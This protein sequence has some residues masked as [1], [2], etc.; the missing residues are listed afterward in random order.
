MN[1][2]LRE[3]KV[4]DDVV[5]YKTNQYSIT[6]RD[7]YLAEFELFKKNDT[8]L[9]NF[10]DEIWICSSGIKR[11]EVNFRYDQI[12]YF[13]H[14]GQK[15]NISSRDMDAMLRC[16]VIYICGGYIFHT[17]ATK[18]TEVKKFITHY[19]D[20]G[21]R[22]TASGKLAILEFLGFI[23][24]PSHEIDRVDRTLIGVQ[25]KPAGQRELSHLI[26]YLAISEEIDS[27]Y[28]DPQ[29]TKEE[30]I[31]WFPVYFWTHVTFIL[32]LRATE[33]LVTPYDCLDYKEQPDGTHEIWIKVSRTQLKKGKR[34]VYY[35]PEKDYKVFEYHIPM[36]DTACMIQKYQ[37][38]TSDQK[39]RFLFVYHNSVNEILSLAA[40]SNLLS[41]F[42][43]MKLKGNPKYDFVRYASGIK[44]FE[45]LSP[46][47][48]RPIAMSNLYFQ[49]AG[50]DICRQ[51]ADHE[52][53][54]TS[55]GYYTNVSNTI[56]ASS[57][58][59]LQRKLNLE[60]ERLNAFENIPTI[61]SSNSDSCLS[62]YRPRQTGNISD[63][64]T[65]GHL[66]IDDCLGCRYYNPSQGELDEAMRAREERL[67]Q[68]SKAVLSAVENGNLNKKNVDFDKLFLDAQTA[69]MRYKV[70]CDKKVEEKYKTWQRYRN[71]AT[72]CF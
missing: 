5:I 3:I 7:K 60:K 66:D 12:G 4:D 67:N 44:E 48:S 39:R 47:D 26:N 11:F 14:I 58:M 33:M 49:N 34:T 16:Y 55:A 8:I 13:R 37:D 24:V 51:L 65:E 41:Q 9:S 42:I 43:D 21:F 35:D 30:F 32:P 54:S 71:T 23:G 69:S 29:T 10:S 62:I 63:C 59:G 28:H 25:P 38:L 6:D 20:K 61:I 68:A 27:I 18:L 64:V 15:Y 22:T 56:L 31:R 40:F 2:A 19:G 70:V 52:N 53:I 36:S 1:N 72:T 57:I 46:G 50:A 17:I 45:L